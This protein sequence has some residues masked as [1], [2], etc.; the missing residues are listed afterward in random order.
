MKMLQAE[1]RIVNRILRETKE[2]AVREKQLNLSGTV[3]KE[4]TTRKRKGN[5]AK[6]GNK[7]ISG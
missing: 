2:S 3:V 4:N 7:S 5:Y 1:L 6:R